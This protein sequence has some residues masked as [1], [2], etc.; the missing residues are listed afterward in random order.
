M[1]PNGNH[2]GFIAEEE[3][4][5]A[6]IIARQWFR[7]HRAFTT[8]VFDKEEREVLRVCSS[9]HN[10]DNGLCKLIL[11]VSQTLLF[12]KVSHPCLGPYQ[13]YVNITLNDRRPIKVQDDRRMPTAMASAAEEVQFVPVP[14]PRHSELFEWDRRAAWWRSIHSVCLCG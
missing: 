14:R 9:C 10:D 11:L 2:V 7:T 6:K 12:H 13:S 4:G 8:H 5:I 1:D 3:S